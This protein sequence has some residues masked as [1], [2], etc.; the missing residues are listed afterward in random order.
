MVKSPRDII[1]A[2]VGHIPEDRH[3]RGLILKYSLFEN[4]MLGIHKNEPFS[5]GISYE[6]QRN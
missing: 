5:K 1:A 4:S 2:G 3:K 6:L